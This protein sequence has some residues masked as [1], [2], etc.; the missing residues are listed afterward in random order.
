MKYFA[1]KYI[2]YGLKDL[3]VEFHKIET[4]TTDAEW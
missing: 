2:D 3:T 4:F 1:Q